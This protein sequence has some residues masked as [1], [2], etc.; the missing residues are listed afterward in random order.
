M[1]ILHSENMKYGVLNG[2]ALQLT[3]RTNNSMRVASSPTPHLTPI[4]PPYMWSFKALI[5]M[6]YYPENVGTE[7]VEATMGLSGG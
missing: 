5:L 4:A 1:L 3:Q 6:F 2:T 7:V